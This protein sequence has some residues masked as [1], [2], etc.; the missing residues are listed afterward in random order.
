MFKIVTIRK[1]C[2]VAST[3]QF[4]SLFLYCNLVKNQWRSIINE[5]KVT[6]RYL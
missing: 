4:T 6:K 3:E 1:N 5:P 2:T